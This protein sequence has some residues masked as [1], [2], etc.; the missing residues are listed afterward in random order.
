MV[1]DLLPKGQ[2]GKAEKLLPVVTAG[3]GSNNSLGAVHDWTAG[4]A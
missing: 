4:R 2:V 1:A 3:R